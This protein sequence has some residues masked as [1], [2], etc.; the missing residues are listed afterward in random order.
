M[1]VIDT[2]GCGLDI[3]NKSVVACLITREPGQQPAKET[4]P[5]RPMTADLLALADWLA[6]MGCTHVAMESAGQYWRPIDHLLEGLFALLLI[7]AQPIKAVPGRKTDG[8]DAEWLA[9]L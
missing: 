9:E 6:A 1:D 3:H 7:N 8:K 2:H 5:L 4:Q